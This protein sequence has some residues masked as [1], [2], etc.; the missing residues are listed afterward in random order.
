[1]ENLIGV[2]ADDTTGAND[3]GVMFSKSKSTV[4]VVTFEE[5][6]KLEKD[7]NVIIVDTDSRLDSL[8][9]SYQ[10]VYH[11]AKMLEQLGCTMYINKTCSVF[12]GNIGS[13]FD[14]MLDALNEEF[15]EGKTVGDWNAMHSG[16]L[17]RDTNIAPLP[18]YVG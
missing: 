5:N 17:I 8:E 11:A 7:A 15:A 4:K 3:I 2:V 16:K 10:K 14:A 6:L 9:L 13:E 12:R 18:R 1:M